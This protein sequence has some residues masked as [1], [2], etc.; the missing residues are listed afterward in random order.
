[1]III[2]AREVKRLSK[3]IKEQ[4]L[5]LTPG[6]TWLTTVNTEKVSI[7][8]DKENTKTIYIGRRK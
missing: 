8:S 5:E 1:M 3:K 6:Q 2:E 7:I 4:Y